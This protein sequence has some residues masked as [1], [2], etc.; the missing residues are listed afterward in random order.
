VRKRGRDIVKDDLQG[1]SG[2]FSLS[3]NASNFLTRGETA[4]AATAA[5]ATALRRSAR[6]ARAEGA[7]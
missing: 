3:R 6:Y 5:A 4:A 2:T 7:F 1:E